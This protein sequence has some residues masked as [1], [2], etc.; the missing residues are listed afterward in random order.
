MMKTISSFLSFKFILLTST[1][2]LTIVCS[3]ASRVNSSDQNSIGYRDSWIKLEYFTKNLVKI[4]VRSLED[5][6][7]PTLKRQNV[8]QQC[9]SSL[10]NF[11]EDLKL[12]KS[13][14]IKGEIFIDVLKHI[15]EQFET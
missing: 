15:F 12:L 6:V 10:I 5:V 4:Y 2:F 11:I 3:D 14:A 8:T 7:L 1:V 9:A 13:D